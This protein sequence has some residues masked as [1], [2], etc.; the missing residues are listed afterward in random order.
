VLEHQTQYREAVKLFKATINRLKPPS[1]FNY[2]ELADLQIHLAW[3]Y[4]RQERF[5][6]AEKTYRL[7]LNLIG[8]KKHHTLLGYIYNGLGHIY[9]RDPNQ[10]AIAYFIKALDH[11]TVSSNFYG[12]QAVYY[13]IG[14]IYRRYADDIL[15]RRKI[16]DTKIPSI[17][18]ANL[19]TAIE[20]AEQCKSFSHQAGVGEDSSQDRILIAYCH[21]QIG[22]LDEALKYIN[23]AKERAMRVRDNKLDLAN[24]AEILWQ[25]YLRRGDMGTAETYLEQSIQLYKEIGL[26]SRVRALTRI[27]RDSHLQTI[28]I[29]P[30]DSDKPGESGLPIFSY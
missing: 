4:S 26:T 11:W 16:G 9:K 24:C 21:L 13:N 20:W 7:A 28:T 15:V 8:N 1:S 12:I 10:K 22:N 6:L 14:S 18:E 5:R 30:S 29:I 3:V 25:I 27:Q 2:Y 23:D 19:N 17:A